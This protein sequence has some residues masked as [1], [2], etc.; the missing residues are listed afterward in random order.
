MKNNDTY[1]K[2]QNQRKEEKLLKRIW[3]ALWDDKDFVDLVQSTIETSKFKNIHS[4]FK[5]I[6]RN[7][8]NLFTI[9]YF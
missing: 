8:H 1:V 5:I 6:N 3:N 7:F 4:G 2:N 9:A